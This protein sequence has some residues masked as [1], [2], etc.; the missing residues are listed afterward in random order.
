MKSFAETLIN[1]EQ[2]EILRDGPL[3]RSFDRL[4]A[5]QPIAPA[6]QAQE[7]QPFYEVPEQKTG[8]SGFLQALA[9]P[10]TGVTQ[11]RQFNKQIELAR[12]LGDRKR[13]IQAQQEEQ[14]RTRE[15]QLNA[16]KFE[17][18]K[19][20][21]ELRN[22]GQWQAFNFGEGADYGFFNPRNPS[23]QMTVG[24]RPILPRGSDGGAGGGN[25][26]TPTATMTY[27]S[28][29][30]RR[31][32]PPDTLDEN[33]RPAY[34]PEQAARLDE[35]VQNAYN[36]WLQDPQRN[37]AAAWLKASSKPAP[38]FDPSFGLGA[39]G[40]PPAPAPS[41]RPAYRGPVPHGSPAPAPASKP[42]F[43]DGDTKNIGGKTYVRKGGQWL[44]Q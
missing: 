10:F 41:P 33:N 4:A 1:P 37:A 23:E 42:Q 5:T 19:V 7:E 13:A 9:E 11:K 8:F 12:E 2:Y 17:Q 30:A 21:A 31:T 20:L 39:Q 35:A 28:Q 16:Q 44:P 3:K 6:P 18:E 24:K 29:A 14:K 15:D 27:L 40:A 43:K 25:P 22:P 38:Q 26:L 32:Y 36:L 34:S